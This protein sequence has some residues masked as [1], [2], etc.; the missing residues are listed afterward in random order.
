MLCTGEKPKMAELKTLA[1]SDPQ[2]KN[3][4][5]GTFS[6]LSSQAL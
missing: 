5:M 6:E 4:L 1:K 3:Y 2:F